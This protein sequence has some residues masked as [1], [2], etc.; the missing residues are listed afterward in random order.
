MTY[1][2]FKI[3]DLYG[4]MMILLQTLINRCL[5][6]L[7]PFNSSFYYFSQNL[8]SIL[9]FLSFTYMTW[10]VFILGRRF[11]SS[12]SCAC[13]FGIHCLVYHDVVIFSGV[14]GFVGE[15]VVACACHYL[16][17]IFKNCISFLPF[18]QDCYLI[19][20]IIDTISESQ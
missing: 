9:C 19:I 7:L 3:Q 11:G 18:L 16:N 14:V 12:G 5:R 20:D 13:F 8:G 1:K 4:V 10:P 15:I 17:I 6:S 2:H